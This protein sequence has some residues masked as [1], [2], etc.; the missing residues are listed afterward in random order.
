MTHDQAFLADCRARL[1]FDLIA[2]T[3]DPVVLWALGRRPHRP[4][5]LVRQIGGISPKALNEALHRLCRAGLVRRTPH[6]GSPPRVEYALTDLGTTLLGPVSALGA[7]AF[8]HGDEVA[9]ALARNE[10]SDQGVEL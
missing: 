7:W 8:E 9:A 6:P 5:E 2:H 1:T 3:W 4:G 10:R